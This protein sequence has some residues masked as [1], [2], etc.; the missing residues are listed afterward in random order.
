MEKVD[1]E[2][3]Q[4][5]SQ[6]EKFNLEFDIWRRTAA[7]VASDMSSA[8]G[9]KGLDRDMDFSSFSGYSMEYDDKGVSLVYNGDCVER[10][11]PHLDS[12]YINGPYTLEE[13]GSL[14]LSEQNLA[15]AKK[16]M[17]KGN[18]VIVGMTYKG[19]TVVGLD[20]QHRDEQAQIA[21][22]FENVRFCSMDMLT[23][24]HDDFIYNKLT[25]GPEPQLPVITLFFFDGRTVRSQNTF[26]PVNNRDMLQIAIDQALMQ[27][28]ITQIKDIRN[29]L[30]EL[31]GVSPEDR[32][33][34][35]KDVLYPSS[36]TRQDSVCLCYNN[37]KDVPGLFTVING[38]LG[39]YEDVIATK[40][41]G[42]P[43]KEYP[44]IT[45]AV[46]DVKR[47][48]LKPE[49]IRIAQSEYASY[50]KNKKTQQ[51]QSQNKGIKI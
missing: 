15:L 10:I 1:K 26:D 37:G 51:Q 41:L 9:W 22:L 33:F 40:P 50:V 28:F 25:V 18:E 11:T 7:M 23:E 24:A 6:S 2:F 14:C 32:P 5:H 27:G 17:N 39:R 34:M 8:C 16:E 36:F 42:K 13:C 49:N 38:K 21:S 19:Y 44:S 3:L 46:A 12:V 20:A 31:A 4:F 43:R 30:D 48:I 29:E 47:V 35:Y 45:A